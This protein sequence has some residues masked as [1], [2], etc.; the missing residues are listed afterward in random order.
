MFAKILI[1]FISLCETWK[2]AKSLVRW[3]LDGSR[4]DVIDDVVGCAAIDC[5]SDALGSSEDFSDGAIQLA[6]H[7]ARTHHLGDV[8]DVIEGDVAAVLDWK[9]GQ[10]SGF[11]S[12]ALILRYSLFFTF[13]L[14]R[15]GSFK[16]FTIMEAADGTT[17][18][19]A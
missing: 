8:D 2:R 3:A 10:V 4:S 14:S 17:E 18:I 1:L 13:F 5:A 7:R 9:N 12:S 16:A 19:A 15:G 11:E 6:G